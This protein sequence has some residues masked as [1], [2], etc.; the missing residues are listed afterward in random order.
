[1]KIFFISFGTTH[2][3]AQ[4]LIRIRKEAEDMNMFD[5]IIIYNENDFDNEF[6]KEHE[7]FMK[8]NKGYGFW[9]WKSYFIKK[10]FELMQDDSILIYADCGSILSNN[11]I[12][13]N[14]LDTYIE[15]CK[16]IPS[17]NIAFSMDFLEKSYTKME[18]LKE[19]NANKNSMLNS[20]QLVGGIF[21][22]R[23]CDRT[24]QLIN[25]YYDSCQKYNLIDDFPS[26]YKNDESFKAHRHDQSIFSILRKE[27]G[28]T[29]ISDN[30]WIPNIYSDEAIGIPII[31]ARI[32]L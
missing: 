24:K 30:T 16:T 18:T 2:N 22:I 9:I 3:Y 14:R 29:L 20:G 32:R 1:M 6:L 17:G 27:M 7:R 28:T 10:T 26:K 11:L 12:A 4:S 13:K 15:L 31:A 5:R 21:L 8:N 19:L 23:K 25:L